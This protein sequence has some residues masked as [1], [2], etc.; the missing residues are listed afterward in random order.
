MV[1]SIFPG[2][3]AGTPSG[4]T[5]GIRCWTTWNRGFTTGALT[6]GP[7]SASPSAYLGGLKVYGSGAPA[8]APNMTN[9]QL[10]SV[11][12]MLSV[13]WFNV[14]PGATLSVLDNGVPVPINLVSMRLPIGGLANGGGNDLVSA[15]EMR[16]K[17]GSEWN[18]LPD[19]IST[20]VPLCCLLS[21][22]NSPNLPL[23]CSLPHQVNGTMVVPTVYGA[24]STTLYAPTSEVLGLVLNDLSQAVAQMSKPIPFNYNSVS[25]LN[26]PDSYTGVLG[27]KVWQGT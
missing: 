7:A 9:M 6:V 8:L 12:Q 16:I 24:N 10:G 26:V 5:Y 4:T 22:L 3:T 23:A 13:D 17:A 15:H 27:S 14:S 25:G 21:R 18:N 11:Y 20:H 2:L 1:Q 19:I